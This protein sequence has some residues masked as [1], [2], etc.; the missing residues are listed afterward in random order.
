MKGYVYLL[1]E[2]DFSGNA[3]GLYKIGKTSQDSIEARTKQ[4][5]AGNARPVVE[6]YSVAVA[7]CQ[8]V[9]TALHREYK[10]YRLKAGGGDEWFRLDGR[11]VADVIQNM[12]S[13]G[14]KR[15]PIRAR[16]HQPPTESHGRSLIWWVFA[17]AGALWLFSV[18][19]GSADIVVGQ[20]YEL[21]QH[22][23]E[24]CPAERQPCN[25]SNVWSDDYRV[26]AT[27]KNGAIV[28]V[29]GRS[30][31]PKYTEVSFASGLRGW[32]YTKSLKAEAKFRTID[33]Q[34]AQKTH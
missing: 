14:T 25:G 7:D 26:I 24:G 6:H 30:Q 28:T 4:Y 3:T 18:R 10:R 19:A 22:P 20:R 9:E 8:Q 31:D 29:T 34:S 2:Q 13:Y 12:R 11:M 15:Q 17:G 5:K 1:Q 21:S 32:V 33:A 16:S 27:I 23:Y